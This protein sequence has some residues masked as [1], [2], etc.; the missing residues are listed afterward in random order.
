MQSCCEDLWPILQRV[1]EPIYKVLY[2]YLLP[3]CEKFMMGSGHQFAYGTTAQ[4]SWHV[5]NCGLISKLF[6][7][8]EQN[9]FSRDLNHELMYA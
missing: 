8:V 5:Q 9:E 4:L 2:N 7:N 1:C 6:V 3:L